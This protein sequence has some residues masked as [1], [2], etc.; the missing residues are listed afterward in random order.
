MVSYFS[1]TRY[2]ALSSPGQ[3]HPKE[4][5]L[6]VYNTKTRLQPHVADREHDLSRIL[7]YT[8]AQNEL[9][10]ATKELTNLLNQ[11]VVYQEE[12]STIFTTQNYL[13]GTMVQL[14]RSREKAKRTY[15]TALSYT[16]E[17][18][19][20]WNHLEKLFNDLQEELFRTDEFLSLHPGRGIYH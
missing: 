5:P 20:E 15:R 17:D 13:P 3:N 2:Y 4:D 19:M 7:F 6:T 18:E 14:M 12:P 16:F 10:D 9:V 8:H 1:E 11:L